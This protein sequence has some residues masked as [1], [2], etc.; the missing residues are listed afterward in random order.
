MSELSE[1]EDRLEDLARQVAARLEEQNK[2]IVFAESCTGGKMAAAMTTVPGIS[3]WFCG[4][5]VTYRETT[6]T[7]WLSVSAS[8]LAQHTAESEFTTVKMAQ[9]VL[10]K[11]READYCVAITGHL[12]PG[13]DST[14]DGKVYA[15]AGRRHPEPPGFVLG[16]LQLESSSRK[17]R[18]TE[19]T[20]FA[21]E[22]FLQATAQ[23]NRL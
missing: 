16:E 1:L 22:L 15:A 5:A 20:C 18:Q 9:G 21:L 14:I 13:V 8:D 7:Q 6:K 19:A 17:T 3:S 23:A 11:T 2:K 10:E 4:S 12:G